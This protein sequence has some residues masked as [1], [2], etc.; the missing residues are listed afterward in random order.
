MSF[1]PRK[2]IGLLAFGLLAS[3]LTLGPEPLCGQGLTSF[4]AKD[5]QRTAL[6]GVR[7]QVKWLQNATRTASH[8]SAGGYDVLGQQYQTLCAS[9][10]DF[11]RTLGPAQWDSAANDLAELDAGLGIIGE[12]F[13]IYQNEVA[14]GRSG[15]AAF[16][17]LCQVLR[18][19]ISLWLQE[20]NRVC[21]RQR[22]GRP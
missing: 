19:G 4:S 1:T 21:S 15:T 9:Y 12:A 3:V 7:S 2:S 22:I 5:T 13:G 10:D 6:N 16:L 11:K 17:D 14:S 8:F 18:D 20:L